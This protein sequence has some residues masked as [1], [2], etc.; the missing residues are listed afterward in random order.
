ME[1][2]YIGHSCFKI[3]GKELTLVIDPYDPKKTGYKLPKMEADVLLLTHDHEDHNHKEGVSGYSFLI[4]GPGE[5]ETKGVFVSGISTYHDAAEGGERGKNTMYFIEIDG[6]T[7]LHL[8]DLG[9]ELSKD[10][11][12]RI[13]NVDVLLVPVGGTYT[14]D[15]VTASKVISMLEPR[16]VVPMHYQTGDLTGLS[17]ELDKI[18]KFLEEMG[19]EGTAEKQEKLKINNNN[20]IPEE[21]QVVILEPQHK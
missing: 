1:I 14:I 12:E 20:D 11:L 4:E 13:S 16:I 3:K 8:G 5:Y 10:M 15:A 19:T 9:H 2:T 7:V 17:E 21:T 18:D 6:F